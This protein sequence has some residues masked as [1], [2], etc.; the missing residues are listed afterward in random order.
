MPS[1]GGID[2]SKWTHGQLLDA[3]SRID[4]SRFPR[5][6]EALTRE[7]ELRATAA[8]DQ[9]PEMQESQA[10]RRPLGV[11]IVVIWYGVLYAIYIPSAIAAISGLLE[12]EGPV[13]AYF[14]S[15]GWARTALAALNGTLGILFV[16]N[17]FFLKRVALQ[18]AIASFVCTQVMWLADYTQHEVVRTLLMSWIASACAGMI[19]VLYTRGLWLRGLLG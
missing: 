11:R 18:Y 10:S 16:W 1:D 15:Y 17:L 2:Y 5:N 13:G 12:L 3:R 14:E 4:G 8:K 9:T 6:Y 19:V 7:L